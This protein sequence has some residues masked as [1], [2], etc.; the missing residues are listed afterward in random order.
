VKA[1]VDCIPCVFLQ[2]LNTSKRITAD[3]K[4]LVDTQR[5]IMKLLPS[6]SLDTTPAELSYYVLKEVYDLHSIKDPFKD[7]RKQSNE[8]M[9][10]LY[11]KMDKIAEFSTDKKYTA[12]KIAA[13]CNIID[14]GILKDFDVSGMITKVLE[15]SFKVDDYKQM[16]EEV[17]RSK[18]I[19]YL[20]DNSGEIVGD[21]LF[22]SSLQRKDITVAVKGKPILNDAVMAD[23]KQV[24]L[25][26]VAK[27]ISTGSGML[28][29]IL[30]DC[31]EEFIN[32]YNNADLVISKGQ[33]N[34]ESLE[35][36]DKNI[37]FI[38]T[39]KCALVASHLGVELNDAVVIKGTPAAAKKQM[40]RV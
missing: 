7:D 37:Y 25:D 5:H 29:T 38:L 10:S 18:N 34:F 16:M 36:V 15:E 9:L 40:P 28:G 8:L 6:L 1:S 30:S 22:L 12:L 31:S 27:V 3:S 13:G 33:A 20:A 24:K 2:A 39:A 35:G 17:D 4:K 23:A 11:D 21:K 26:E 14:M 32:L 19:L